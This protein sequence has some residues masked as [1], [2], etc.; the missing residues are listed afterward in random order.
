MQLNRLVGNRYINNNGNTFHDIKSAIPKTDFDD[1]HIINDSPVLGN[2]TFTIKQYVNN[3]TIKISKMSDDLSDFLSTLSIKQL[4][5][6]KIKDEWINYTGFKHIIDTS[7]RVVLIHSPSI[8]IGRKVDAVICS[9]YFPYPAKLISYSFDNIKENVK[10]FLEKEITAT[11]AISV[12]DCGIKLNNLVIDK[13]STKHFKKITLNGHCLLES[14]LQLDCE[15]LIINEINVDIK[16]LILSDKFQVIGC[17]GC[18]IPMFEEGE[19]ENVYNLIDC[20]Y[21]NNE[22]HRIVTRNRK[23]K[24]ESRFKKVKPIF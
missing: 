8:Y 4:T 22:V 9:E 5:L 21:V 13:L 16:K 11:E 14:V 24:E 6:T 23:Y 17:Y 10:I 3:L 20:N 7:V 1:I 19:L 2:I 12:N 18:G 15:I